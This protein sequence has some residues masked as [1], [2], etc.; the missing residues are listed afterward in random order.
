[1][2]AATGFYSTAEDLCRYASAHFLGNEELLSDASKREMQQGYW[3]IEQDDERY[4]LGFSAMTIGKRRLFGHGGG[5]PGHSTKTWFDPKERLVV[6]VLTN[7]SAGRA[8]TLARGV[9][10]IT[11]FALSRPAPSGEQGD[12]E[13]RR[14]TGRFYSLW[15]VMDVARFGDELFALAPGE[16]DPVKDVTALEIVDENT[17]RITQ[18]NGY[19]SPGETM[20]YLRDD[21]GEITRVISGGV[22]SYPLEIYRQRVAQLRERVETSV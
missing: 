8:D 19:S 3:A 12:V 10:K 18:T 4:G 6:V 16:D 22:S 9:V 11:D 7:E 21:S 15:G 5:F 20:R 14:F 17:L 1:M 13:N 2:A